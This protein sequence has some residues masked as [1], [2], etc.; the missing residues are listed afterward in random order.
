MARAIVV[1]FVHDQSVDASL[2]GVSVNDCRNHSAD[3]VV[4][5]DVVL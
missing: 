4:S 2:T 3:F 5:V 1:V